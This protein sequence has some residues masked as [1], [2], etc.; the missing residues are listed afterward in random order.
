MPEAKAKVR[1][2]HE[3]AIR[4]FQ[5]WLDANPRA[6]RA[7]RIQVFDTLVDGIRPTKGKRV[8][9]RTPR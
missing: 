5:R 4:E 9:L 7:R 3:E 8:K 1:A 6:K 2:R